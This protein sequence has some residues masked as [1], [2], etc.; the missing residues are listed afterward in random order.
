MTLSQSGN[1]LQFRLHWL[2]EAFADANREIG[3][4]RQR[5]RKEGQDLASSRA[6]VRA[7]EIRLQGLRDEAA[8]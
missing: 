4:L 5:L 7:L 2:E 8:A 6:L 3:E 1:P